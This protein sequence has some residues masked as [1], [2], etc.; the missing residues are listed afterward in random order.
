[1][2]NF[3]KAL[4]KKKNLAPKKFLK[5]EWKIKESAMNYDELKFSYQSLFMNQFILISALIWVVPCCLLS[6]YLNIYY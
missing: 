3:F 5:N 1:M 4:S 2:L 6:Q